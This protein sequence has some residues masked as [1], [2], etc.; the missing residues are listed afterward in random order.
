[1]GCHHGHRP[2]QALP[3][4]CDLSHH[5]GTV[6]TIEN[7]GF[8]LISDDK[9]NFQGFVIKM[10]GE[11]DTDRKCGLFWMRFCVSRD[12]FTD[13]TAWEATVRSFLAR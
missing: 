9:I 10:T 7:A 8:I 6:K 2:C 5:N 3:S 12:I 1:M 13:R 4:W 11:N